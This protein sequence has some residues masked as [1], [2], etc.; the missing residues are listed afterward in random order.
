MIANE[1]KERERSQ[2]RHVAPSLVQGEKGE[3]AR[4]VLW[5]VYKVGAKVTVEKKK[6]HQPYV[7]AHCPLL[8]DASSNPLFLVIRL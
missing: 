4:P 1:E 7:R 2:R 8:T 3:R 5:R 6:G